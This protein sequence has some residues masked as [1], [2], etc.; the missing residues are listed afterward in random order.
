MPSHFKSLHPPWGILGLSHPQ[1]SRWSLTASFS[2]SLHHTHG[3]ASVLSSLYV[4]A[5]GG[6]KKILEGWSV[7]V[8]PT[9]LPLRTWILNGTSSP[10][11]PPLLH[12]LPVSLTVRLGGLHGLQ[13][14]QSMARPMRALSPHLYKAFSRAKASPFWIKIHVHPG[15]ASILILWENNAVYFADPV[16]VL[17]HNILLFFWNGR[18]SFLA[19]LTEGP[20][21]PNT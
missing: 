2:K 20:I 13:L 8:P 12:S 16:T 21:S 7:G 14:K 1:G 5:R 9:C 4:I 17:E 6:L 15:P 11:S 3:A 10:H 19:C 18:L